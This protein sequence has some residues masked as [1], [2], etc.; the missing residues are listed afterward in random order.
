MIAW[1]SFD[2]IAG[3]VSDGEPITEWIDQGRNR[4]VLSARNLPQPPLYEQMGFENRGDCLNFA[5]AGSGLLCA[6]YHANQPHELMLI[7]FNQQAAVGPRGGM[8]FDS[9]G[10]PGQVQSVLFPTDLSTWEA[11]AGTLAQIGRAPEMGVWRMWNWLFWGTRSR[12]WN[13]GIGSGRRFDPGANPMNGLTLGIAN[14]GLSGVNA[15]WG[16]GG[17]VLQLATFG[18]RLT[19]LERH[20][21]LIY[22]QK[23]YGGRF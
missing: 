22:F 3:T 20:G 13:G 21:L 14:T 11:V 12:F 1:W 5:P 16:W 7:G 4:Y 19:G 15:D 10:V 17:S 6:N 23:K 9:N 2:S 18:D 8:V